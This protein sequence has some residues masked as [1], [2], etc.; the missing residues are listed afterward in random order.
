[1]FVFGANVDVDPT[2]QLTIVNFGVSG[3]DVINFAALED[4]SGNVIDSLDSGD[5]NQ[6]ALTEKAVYLIGAADFDPSNVATAIN[7]ADADGVTELAVG[8]VAYVF[9]QDGSDTAIFQYKDA[10]GAGVDA[11]ELV[12]VG[13]IYAVLTPGDIVL[14]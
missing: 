13:T 9:V 11:N 8:E 12:L 5:G 10:A 6:F 2:S 14:A 3:V 1:I 7:I 4:A